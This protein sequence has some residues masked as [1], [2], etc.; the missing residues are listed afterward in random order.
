MCK[1]GGYGVLGLTLVLFVKA[2]GFGLD[3]SA[4]QVS[5]PVTYKLG[6]LRGKTD[7][8][9]WQAKHITSGSPM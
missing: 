2:H 5:L 8:V 4:G 9:L 3:K 1:G 6:V 7:G